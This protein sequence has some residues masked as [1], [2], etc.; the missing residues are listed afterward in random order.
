[1]MPH[2]LC[3]CR[4]PGEVTQTRH[5]HAENTSHVKPVF[6]VLSLSVFSLLLSLSLS[7]PFPS[8]PAP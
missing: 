5:S 8:P 2:T 4:A 3:H 1:M 7:L 6:A